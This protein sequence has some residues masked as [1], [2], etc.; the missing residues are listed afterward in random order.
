MVEIGARSNDLSAMLTLLAGLLSARQCAAHAP[1]GLMVYPL[2]VII[3]ALGLTL[4]LSFVLR[5][6][7]AHSFTELLSGIFPA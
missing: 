6:F 4:G 1:E 5:N 2:I 3:V 7:I